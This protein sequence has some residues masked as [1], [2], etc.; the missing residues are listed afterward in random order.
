ME[1][2]RGDVEL[3]LDGEKFVLRAT[4]QA[5]ADYQA[6][7]GVKGILPVIELVGELHAE[8]LM[9]GVRCLGSKKAAKRLGS[10]VYGDHHKKV[11]DAIMLAMAGSLDDGEDEDPT[12]EK[13]KGEEN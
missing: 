6:A 10:L 7:L 1:H 3:D 11:Q 8:A 2:P 13:P 5:M 4:F 9:E 12:P